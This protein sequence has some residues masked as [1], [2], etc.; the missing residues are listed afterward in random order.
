MSTYNVGQAN[1]NALAIGDHAQA[2]N[3]STGP[4]PLDQLAAAVRDNRA[5]LGDPEQVDRAL[6]QL[7][8]LVAED[9]DPDDLQPLLG[10]IVSN[11]QQAPAVLAAAAGLR[12]T[13]SA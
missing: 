9:A 2:T 10:V 8:Q 13:G 6:R 1:A 12:R 5:R 7:R 3:G 11:A 4:D